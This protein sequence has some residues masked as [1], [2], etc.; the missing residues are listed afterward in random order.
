MIVVVTLNLG[1]RN[2]F[3]PKISLCIWHVDKAWRKVLARYVS[4]VV[5]VMAETNV[6][7]F[8]DFIQRFMSFLLS[9]YF[10]MY[11]LNRVEE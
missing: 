10:K 2:S 4:D 3:Y 5:V 11:Y 8:M 6:Q 1:V 9:S 7:H